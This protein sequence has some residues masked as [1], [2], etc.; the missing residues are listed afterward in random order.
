L[1]DDLSE[2]KSEKG[3]SGLINRHDETQKYT[4]HRYVFTDM[5]SPGRKGSCCENKTRHRVNRQRVEYARILWPS[6]VGTRFSRAGERGVK[7]RGHLSGRLVRE[8][9]EP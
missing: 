1:G 7:K 9:G 5:S 4:L 6:R 2:G 8:A 3:A